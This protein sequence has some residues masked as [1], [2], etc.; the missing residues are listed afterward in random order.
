MCDFDLTINEEDYSLYNDEIIEFRLINPENQVLDH[1]SFK[2][3]REAE[4]YVL[5]KEGKYFFF[6][7]GRYRIVKLIYQSLK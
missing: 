1:P 4:E 7:K 6:P 2:T 5:S 3:K